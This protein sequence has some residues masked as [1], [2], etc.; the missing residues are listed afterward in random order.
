MRK[1]LAVL[2]ITGVLLLALSVPALAGASHP[3]NAWGQMMKS[4]NALLP[5]EIPGET[6][7][8]RN[9]GEH[10]LLSTPIIVMT[11]GYPSGPSSMITRLAFDPVNRR[12]IVL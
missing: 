12:L 1:L 10:M 7:V 8:W 6:G 3:P 9:L 2:I 4:T 11:S 5:G